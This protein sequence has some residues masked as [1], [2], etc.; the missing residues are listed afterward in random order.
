MMY[1]N[2]SAGS[3]VWLHIH[4]IFAGLA[5]FGFIAA[6]LWLQKHASKKDFLN[7][8]WG[9]LI[10]GLIG[11]ILTASVAMQGWS[12]MMEDYHTTSLNDD[13]MEEMWKDMEEYIDENN[14][15]TED[16]KTEDTKTEDIIDEM[17][18]LNE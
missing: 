8:V 4:W 3:L 2:T 18:D 1:S 5:L 15:E 10:V 6:L 9:S 14:N 16:T 11:G 17:M 7:I 12:Q 13:D